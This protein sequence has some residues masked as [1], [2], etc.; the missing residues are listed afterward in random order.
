MDL[1]SQFM[2]N[3]KK[4]ISF[5]E[6]AGRLAASQVESALQAAGIR[7][8]VTSRAKNP[9]RLKVKVLRRNA[10]RI[11]PY[12]N[13]KE[14]YEDIADLCG[15]RIS[16]YFP[17]DRGKAGDL[18]QDLF[19][20][21]EIRRFPEQSKTPTYNKRFS[22]YWATHYR[23]HLKEDSLNRTQQKF[24]GV[25]IEIQVASLLMHAWSEVE[26]DLVYKPMQGNLSDEELAI[27][28]ELNG[29]VLT[30]EIALEQLQLAGNKRVINKNATFSSQYDLASY[31]YNYLSSNFRREDVELRMGNIEL[32]FKL[33][34]RLQMNSVKE[35]EPVLKSVKFEKDRRN[36]SQQIIDQIITGSE[37]RY[38]T[39][40]ELR[41]GG[42]K[43]EKTAARAVSS[44]FASWVPL[45]ALLNRLTYRNSPKTRGAFNI[46][47]LKRMGILKQDCI[48]Q[49]ASLRKLRN[50]L[51]HDI[52][53][54]AP[55]EILKRAEEAREL[56]ERLTEELSGEIRRKPADSEDGF[57]SSPSD[58]PEHS[59][60][61]GNR[62]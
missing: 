37:K 25:R 23:A 12:K 50:V 8:M 42:V 29:L 53:I 28:D 34:S 15:V 45:E 60:Q 56:L 59:N 55:E 19:Q 40:Q 61:Q 54:P 39:Y 62:E 3:Y 30:G 6:T 41:S 51:I 43:A 7:A 21:Q 17:G 48:S 27:I 2:E 18:V 57:V 44:F 32:L 47:T 14:I 58:M 24:A 49:I 10:E 26:H 16:L 1:I 22:G 38:K 20:V 13:M 36:I 52:E 31:L 33:I 5:Y 4:K 35:I 9:V 46:N 11:I